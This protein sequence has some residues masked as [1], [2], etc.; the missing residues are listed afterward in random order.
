MRGT[1]PLD[2]QKLERELG[3]YRRECNDLGARLLRLQEEQSQA[4][5]EARRSRTV[6]K[7]IREAHRLADLAA[8][9]EDL[10]GPLLEVIAENT[11]CDRAAFVQRTTLPGEPEMFR[12]TDQVGFGAEGAGAPV[13][14]PGTARTASLHI[15]SATSR[16]CTPSAGAPV[17]SSTSR[18]RGA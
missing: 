17:C 4:F 14:V 1:N 13:P 8:T 15:T 16:S 9:A 3:Y 5:R 12:V 7:L 18:P 11:L 6:V 2:L 10:G